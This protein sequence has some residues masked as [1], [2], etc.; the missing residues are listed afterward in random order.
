MDHV[1]RLR[2]DLRHGE[3]EPEPEVTTPPVV[4]PFAVRVEP[5][6]TADTARAQQARIAVGVVDGFVHGNDVRQT[7]GFDLL[8]RELLTGETGQFGVRLRELALV[9][10]GANLLRDPVVVLEEHV[11]ENGDFGRHAAG[12][13]E[14]RRTEH[15][16]G[17]VSDAETVAFQTLDPVLAGRAVGG[18]AE[19]DDA[20]FLAPRTDRFGNREFA[21]EKTERHVMATEPLDDGVELAGGKSGGCE[22]CAHDCI[23]LG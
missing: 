10:L 2:T 23:S 13:L 16:L 15:L 18:D 21:S 9:G 5:A 14:V 1:Q 7:H 12:R 6:T 8:V 22:F 19:V 20:V 17:V 3:R 11:L 4:M